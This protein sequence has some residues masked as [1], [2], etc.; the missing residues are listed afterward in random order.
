VTHAPDS[1]FHGDAGRAD[2][3]VLPCGG[4]VKAMV[5]TARELTKDLGKD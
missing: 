1:L 2:V 5:T 3:L 4:K